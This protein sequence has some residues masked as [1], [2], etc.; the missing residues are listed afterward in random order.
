[1][2]ARSKQKGGPK[3]L[4]ITIGS[5]SGRIPSPLLASYS[6][7]KAALATWTKALAEEVKPQGVIVELVQAAFVVSPLPSSQIPIRAKSPNHKV[8]NMSKIRKPSPFVPTPAPFVRSTLNSIGLPRGAQGRP[9]ERTPFW[10]HA[11][12]DYAVGFAGYVSEMAGIKVI[13][14]MHN[15]I[16]KRALKKAARDAKKAE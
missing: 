7:T 15:D 11:I 2:V 1:M 16:R 3:S 4:V 12:L 9:H 10:S 5:L 14:G 6:G 13:L 8:S